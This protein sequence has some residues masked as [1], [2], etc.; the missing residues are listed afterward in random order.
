[1]KHFRFSII[2]AIIA[3]GAMAIWGQTKGQAIEILTL[4]I[5]LSFMEISFSFD[6]AVLNATILKH[7]DKYWQTIFLTVGMII[8]VFGMR[9]LFPII[10]VSKTADMG[11][12]E[13]WN[14]A[15]SD[16]LAYSEKLSMHHAEISA[17]GG[18]FLL[19]VFLNFLLDENKEI[20]W[21]SYIEKQISRLGKVDAISI[22][23]TLIIVMFLISFIDDNS[24]K[25]SVLM[26]SIWGIV[27]YLGVKFIGIALEYY[28]GIDSKDTLNAIAKGGFGSFLYLEVLDASFSFDGVIGSFAI[29]KDIIVIMVGLGIGAFFVR[30]M[31]IYLVENE[32]LDDY[33]YLEHGAHYAIGALALIMLVSIVGLEIPEVITGL[34]GIFFILI[35]LYSSIKEKKRFF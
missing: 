10:I 32:T 8:A 26:A 27:T 5:I 19:L 35:A 24:E 1:V 29:T 15:L 12:L 9:L 33:I 34:I 21:L 14:L 20:H 16:P 23:I 17:F 7:W 28:Q 2:F 31:T 11:L 13:S 3:L 18:V 6:N 30:S 22:L 25:L 4:T